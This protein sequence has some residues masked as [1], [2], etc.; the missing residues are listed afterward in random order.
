M[1]TVA[2]HLGLRLAW[3]RAQRGIQQ[4]LARACYF[5]GLVATSCWL[6]IRAL[7]RQRVRFVPRRFHV[8]SCAGFAGR[9]EHTAYGCL[10]EIVAA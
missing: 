6:F 9:P 4:L 5:F 2:C 1:V 3:D 10:G 7:G 8:G